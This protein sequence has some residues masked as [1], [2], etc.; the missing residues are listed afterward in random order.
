MKHIKIIIPLI[1]LVCM[2]V[3]CSSANKTL[4]D[5]GYR[6]EIDI[7]YMTLDDVRAHITDVKTEYENMSI[8]PNALKA[9]ADNFPESADCVMLRQVSNFESK[10]DVLRPCFISNEL[11]EKQYF[12]GFDNALPAGYFY[13]DGDRYLNVSS[14]GGIG[15]TEG[16]SAYDSETVETVFVN[17]PYEDK[18]YILSGEKYRVSEGVEYING[19]L[20]QLSENGCGE[21]R[22]GYVDILKY[23]KEYA[24]FFIY[25]EQ[26][27]EWSL[28]DFFTEMEILMNILIL[29]L[30]YL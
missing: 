18:E 24:F 7:K 10:Y 2:L 13:D 26:L 9:I 8:D 3:S 22:I 15:F 5:E 20:K 28:T 12:M 27:T 30:R 16:D 29:A 6:S 21:M 19:F 4:T 23:D 14:N 17:R 1:I 25:K 11:Y